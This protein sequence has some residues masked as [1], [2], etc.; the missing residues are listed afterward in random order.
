MSDWAQRLAEDIVADLEWLAE[1]DEQELAQLKQR[2]L[3][4]AYSLMVELMRKVP[5]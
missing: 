2:T 5:E 3:W 1:M 4:R